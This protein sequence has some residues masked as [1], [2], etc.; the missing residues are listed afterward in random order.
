V[1][2]SEHGIASLTAVSVGQSLPDIVY[3]QWLLTLTGDY[4]LKD[5][6]GIKLKYGFVHVTARDWTWDGFIYAD[7]TTVQ[8]PDRE[9]THFAGL[10]FYY[11]W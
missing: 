6:Y 4:A 5:N 11:R 8:I 2:T 3:R 9:Q 1:D 10:S 7:G